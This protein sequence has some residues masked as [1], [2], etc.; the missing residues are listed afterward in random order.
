MSREEKCLRVVGTAY[1]W[2]EGNN[3]LSLI[4]RKK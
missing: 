2:V 4:R 1:V 3:P